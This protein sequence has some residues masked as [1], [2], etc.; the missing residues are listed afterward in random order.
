MNMPINRHNLLRKYPVI[1][2]CHDQ[3]HMYTHKK[4]LKLKKKKR[5]QK[6]KPIFF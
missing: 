2:L 4:Y 1:I 5:D 3:I 6:P